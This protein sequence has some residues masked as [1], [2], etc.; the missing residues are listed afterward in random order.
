MT[1]EVKTY[2]EVKVVYSI[3]GIAKIRYMQKKMKL[4]HKKNRKKEKET[5]SPTYTIHKN[6][7]KMD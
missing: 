3:N 6:K 5:R 2:N 7:L 1:K 4:D